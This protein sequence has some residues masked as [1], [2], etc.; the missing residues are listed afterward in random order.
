VAA[1]D[2]WMKQHRKEN[3]DRWPEKLAFTLWAGETMRHQGVMESQVLYALGVK[4]RWD[5]A[6][7]MAGLGVLPAAELKRP[8][9]DV[10]ISVTGSYRDQFPVVMRWIDEA[11]R[12]VAQ[13]KEADNGIA[14]NTQKLASQFL[15]QGASAADAKRWSTARVFSNEQGSYSTGLSDAAQAT[16]I[17]KKA[18]KGGGDAEMAQLYMDRMGHAYGQGI[19][20]A[21][22]GKALQNAYARNLAQ[23]DAALLSRTSNTYGVLTSDDPFQYL[24]GIAQAVRQ[25]TGKD[26]ALYVQNLRDTTEVTTESASSAIAKEMQTRYLHPQWITAQKAEGYSGT[27]QVLKTA[28]FLWGWQVTAPQTVRQDH[29][30]SLHNVYVRDQYKL[31]TRE[32]LEGSNR[33]AFAQ[34]LE[35]MLDAVR[36]NYWQPDEATQ[37]ELTQA[38][39]EA[40]KAT[41]L[42]ESNMAVQRF[43]AAQ[44]DA[45]PSSSQPAAAQ[46]APSKQAANEAK[47]EPQEIIKGLKLELQVPQPKPA[48]SVVNS[49]ATLWGVALLLG[50][51]AWQQSR[52]W[53]L[54]KIPN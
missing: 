52:R 14:R 32:W 36:L 27:L 22:R 17:W 10:L 16:D 8:R 37:R 45:R 48:M 3:N 12:Q 39:N 31:G 11:V 9:L 38:Y 44:G 43:A 1:F 23:V 49:L 25:L 54:A 51:G 40:L 18:D 24:G 7:R 4:P 42:R 34:T 13:L 26:P 47:A 5:D 15:A 19:D 6:G 20:G 41:G 2:A 46:P 35:R 50:L 30:Q 29:W 33:A 28:Q 53:R 21:A